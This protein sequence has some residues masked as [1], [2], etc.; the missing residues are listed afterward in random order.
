MAVEISMTTR[1]QK[2]GDKVFPRSQPGS[3]Q[4]PFILFNSHKAELKR[5]NGVFEL[6]IMHYWER[7][8]SIAFIPSGAP[9]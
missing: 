1:T 6:Y 5:R 3:L 9:G 7:T 2:K 8:G 4:V